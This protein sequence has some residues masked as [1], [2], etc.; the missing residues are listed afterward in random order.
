MLFHVHFGI[1]PKR[2][3]KARTFEKL[4]APQAPFFSEE[5]SYSQSNIFI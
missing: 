2:T 4:F 1:S 5:R 3:K